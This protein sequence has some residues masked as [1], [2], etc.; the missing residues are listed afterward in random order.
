MLKKIWHDPGGSKVI[1]TA[2]IAIVGSLTVYFAG[3]WQYVKAA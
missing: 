2:I 3:W 1:A